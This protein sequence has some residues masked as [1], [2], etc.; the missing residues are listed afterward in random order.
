MD[1]A[2]LWL[3]AAPFFL[4]RFLLHRGFVAISYTTKKTPR[5]ALFRSTEPLLYTYASASI[6]SC[7]SYIPGAFPAKYF[8][9]EIEPFANTA[10]E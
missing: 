9:A 10:L 7:I 4:G 2:A 6:T 5:I 1:K 8:A 3:F